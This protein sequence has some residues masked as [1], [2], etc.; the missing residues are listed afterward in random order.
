MDNGTAN[1]QIARFVNAGLLT[2]QAQG[3]YAKKKE[4]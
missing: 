1:K 3:I 4:Q 2:R